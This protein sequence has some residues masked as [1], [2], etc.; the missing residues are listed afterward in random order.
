MRKYLALAILAF[1]YS[2]SAQAFEFTI[3][4][5]FAAKPQST[6]IYLH[7]SSLLGQTSTVKTVDVVLG[8]FYYK[9]TADEPQQ[10]ILAWDKKLAD[11]K[12][13]YFSFILDKGP[14]TINIPQGLLTAKVSGSKANTD[15]QLFYSQQ[16]SLQPEIEKFN[17]DAQLAQAAST[18]IDSL[19][20]VFLPRLESLQ[21]SAA[22]A[23]AKFVRANPSAFIS[24][25]ILP[26]MAETSKSYL[27][28]D[29]LFHL[30]AEDVRNTPSGKAIKKQIDTEK[31]ISVGTYAPDFE[32]PDT[33]N[34]SIKL[35]DLRGKYVLI[36][37][38]AAWC[39]PCR[40]ENPNVVK[41]YNMYKDKGFTILGVSLDYDRTNWL[42]AIKDDGLIWHQ[43]SDLKYW[44]NAAAKIYG[45]QAIPRNFLVNDK[46]L[47]IARDLRGPELERIL[48]K[49]IKTD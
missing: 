22:R 10:C 20:S 46:G 26:E 49:S 24:L 19:R 28:A 17:Q 25:L 18:N 33:S 48:R 43:V 8:K 36:D 38:W 4:G 11:D 42:K 39:G 47:I 34:K 14:I 7:I 15:F 2:F 27:Q 29:T 23:Q 6:K 13:A 16:K 45:I 5:A 1:S 35:S 44:N 3:K 21:N 41:A 40:Q 9:G 31:K 32:L 30:L 37:F 12:A